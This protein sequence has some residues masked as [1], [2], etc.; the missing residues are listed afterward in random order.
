MDLRQSLAQYAQAYY[1]GTPLVSDEEYDQLAEMLRAQCSTDPILSQVGAPVAGETIRHTTPMLSLDKCNGP[2]GFAKWRAGHPGALVVRPKYDGLAL[3]LVYQDGLL[4]YAA[5]RGD[6]EEGEDATLNAQEIPSVLRKINCAGR[7]E[8][9]GEVVLPVATHNP[10]TDFTTH[11]RNIAAGVMARKRQPPVGV[12]PTDLVFYA[13]DQLGEPTTTVIQDIAWLQRMGFD[14]GPC[15]MHSPEDKGPEDWF[16]DK[17]KWKFPADGVVIRE[18]QHSTVAG[19][20]HHP[21]HSIAWKFIA[22][23]S[24][25][26]AR[27]VEWQTTRMGTVTPVVVFDAVQ[28]EGATV[29]R[30]TLHSLGRLETLGLGYADRIEIARRGGVIPH[31]ERVV[32]SAGL[33]PF[34]PP[35][36]CT[37]CGHRLL[38]LPAVNDKGE[39]ADT[40]NCPNKGCK[41]QLEDAIRHWCSCLEMDGFGPAVCA[42]LATKVLHPTGIYLLNWTDPWFARNLGPTTAPKLH[43]EMLRCTQKCTAVGLLTAMGLPGVGPSTAKELASRWTVEDLFD[44]K[45]EELLS[46]PGIGGVTASTIQAGFAEWLPY[47][48][49]LLQA[50]LL[51]IPPKLESTK[52]LAGPLTGEVICFTGTLSLPRKQAQARALE[53]GALVESDVSKAVTVLVVGADELADQQ[54]AKFRKAVTKGVTIWDEHTFLARVAR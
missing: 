19:T 32:Q 26:V 49:M 42:K 31:V 3:S 13:Y 33:S 34:L 40:L 39:K 29:S 20:S 46:V 5:T 36:L 44:V 45:E 27:E 22:A 14:V 38:R 52:R 47:L 6:G 21:A 53:A 54:S 28:T 24:R 43:K 50:D 48:A 9:R 41:A 51:V 11:P 1:D 35:E 7:R 37:S 4:A 17:D 18:L 15:V 2:E 23:T 16:P 8:V 25:S 10:S 12:R 30:A